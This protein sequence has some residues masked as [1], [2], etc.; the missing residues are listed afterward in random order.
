MKRWQQLAGLALSWAILV[1]ASV[2]WPMSYWKPLNIQ[3]VPTGISKGEIGLR[4]GVEKGHVYCEM[5]RFVFEYSILEFRERGLS[6]NGI[7][8]W[9]RSAT[10]IWSEL[11][12]FEAGNKT[13]VLL[14]GS[15]VMWVVGPLWVIILLA[16]IFPFLGIVW[17]WRARRRRLAGAGSCP[18]CGYDLRG[19]APTSACPECGA[20]R[21]TASG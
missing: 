1:I 2:M 8:S 5:E 18:A 9:E 19:L 15:D 14:P 6:F 21:T 16:A 3:W 12:Y 17:R 7:R 13:G 20:A 10:A 4:A 11:L